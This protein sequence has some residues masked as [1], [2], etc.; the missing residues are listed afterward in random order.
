MEKVRNAIIQAAGLG[1]RCVPLTYDTPK[2]LLKIHGKPIIEYAIEQLLEVGITEIIVIVNYKKKMFDYLKKKY[3]VTLVINPE[4]LTKNTLSS[5]YYALDYLDSSYIICGDNLS[6]ANLFNSHEEKSWMSCSFMQQESKD[7]WFVNLDDNQRITQ[8]LIGGSN[9]YVLEGPAYFSSSFSKRIKPYMLNYYNQNNT[10]NFYWADVL[11]R[12]LDEFPIYMC[13]NTN[14]IFDLDDI[15][16]LRKVDSFYIGDAGNYILKTICDVFGYDNEIKN[17]APIKTGIT[18]NSFSFEIQEKKYVYRVA[19]DMSDNLID[20]KKEN[21]VYE[22]IKNDKISD[23]VIYFNEENGHRISIFL[24]D[25]RHCNIND[26]DDVTKCVNKLKQVHNKDYKINFV[27]DLFKQIEMHEAIWVGHG[28]SYDDY[29]NTK[30]NI[31][32]LQ[33]YF[34]MFEKEYVLCHIDNS[35]FNFLFAGENENEFLHLIDWEYAAMQEL[36][37]DLIAFAVFAN[38]DK[39]QIDRMLD[40]YFGSNNVKEID[41]IKAYGYTSILG[42]LWYLWYEHECFKEAPYRKYAQVRY[43]YAVDFYKLFMDCLSESG[44]TFV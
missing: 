35:N 25:T 12:H 14:K 30:A 33:K 21:A 16:S 26:W 17:I 32:S 20:R 6:D 44:I 15:E 43:A 4:S 1:S 2:A 38:Y 34:G 10:E 40:I 29:E 9:G 41:R 18:N 27:F 5:L 11:I 39:D 19:R 3:G 31:L 8:V 13:D 28:S 7:E 37:L 36:H 24:H 23:E 22:L 42:F